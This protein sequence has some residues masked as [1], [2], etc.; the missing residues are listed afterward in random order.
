MEITLNKETKKSIEESTG[1]KFEDILNMD[2]EDIAKKIEKKIGKKLLFSTSND[3]RLP[4]R[5]SVYLY[6]KRFL[7]Y[8][9]ESLD[10]Y[11]DSLTVLK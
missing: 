8:D 3:S 2:S 10:K 7:N 1:L 5:G 9:T 4:S 11:I 6:L